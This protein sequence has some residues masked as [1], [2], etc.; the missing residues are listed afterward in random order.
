MRVGD[1]MVQDRSFGSGNNFMAHAIGPARVDP[2]SNA[3][4]FIEGRVR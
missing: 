4:V 3:R 2:G 1:V